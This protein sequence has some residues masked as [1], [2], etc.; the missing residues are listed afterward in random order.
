MVMDYNRTEL[1]VG[2]THYGVGMFIFSKSKRRKLF[3]PQGDR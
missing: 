2:L 3:I 1:N